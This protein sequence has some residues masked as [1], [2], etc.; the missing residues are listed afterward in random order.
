MSPEELDAIERDAMCECGAECAAPVGRD[1]KTLELVAEIRRLW[2][3]RCGT[4]KAEDAC[5]RGKA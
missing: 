2:S 4:C 1:E 3:E 5:E